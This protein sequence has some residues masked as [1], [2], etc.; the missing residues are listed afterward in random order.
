MA[1]KVMIPTPLRQFTGKQASIECSA[2]T[3]GEALGSLT[4]HV[5]PSCASISLPTTEKF[6]A[7]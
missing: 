5:L 6:A 7:S 4:A 3:V 1:V 2:A